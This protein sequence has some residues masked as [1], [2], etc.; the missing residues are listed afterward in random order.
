LNQLN[1][2]K[3]PDSSSIIHARRYTV[4]S[5]F[6]GG[7]HLVVEGL[8]REPNDELRKK[9]AS[10][11]EKSILDRLYC[12]RINTDKSLYKLRLIDGEKT[13]QNQGLAFFF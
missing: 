3:N 7:V 5:C 9:V 11:F 6:E 8:E 12:I 1:I 4:I 10:E 2:F 13:F